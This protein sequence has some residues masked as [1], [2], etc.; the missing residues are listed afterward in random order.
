MGPPTR[1][2]L[3]LIL[4]SVA[5]S[6][7][8]SET[9]APVETAA[10]TLAQVTW[11]DQRIDLY[12]IILRIPEDW[13]VIEENRRPAPA[14]A[15]TAHE[16]ADYLV[17]NFAGT[18][19][20]SLRPQCARLETALDPAVEDAVV[21]LERQPQE[22][23]IRFYDDGRS[24][25]AYTNAT[26]VNIGGA[27]QEPGQAS[28]QANPPVISIGSGKDLLLLQIDLSINSLTLDTQTALDLADQIVSSLDVDG[29]VSE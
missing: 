6:G 12:G 14:G 23:I 24:L 28:L 25:Y 27:T 1:F 26:M 15:V 5:L 20:L 16:C 2:I 3:L 18:V 13:T 8:R 21:I 29:S 9:P 22:F 17:R 10:P 11:I 19:R 7:C 4:T